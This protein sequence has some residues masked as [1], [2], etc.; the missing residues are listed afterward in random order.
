MI[1]K[2]LSISE[3]RMTEFDPKTKGFTLDIYTSEG[4]MQKAYK[5][6]LI[7][8]LP[9]QILNDIK[10]EKFPSDDEDDDVLPGIKLINIRDDEVIKEALLKSFLRLGQRVLDSYRL[11]E[12]SDYMKS[13]KALSTS[14]EIIYKK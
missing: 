3:I 8:A 14:Q 7:N 6:V 11:T 9:D 5:L 1:V 13:Y 10:K 2:N 4:T 12:A